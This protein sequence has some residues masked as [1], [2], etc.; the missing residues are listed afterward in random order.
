MRLPSA[1]LAATVLLCASAGAGLTAPVRHGVASVKGVKTDSYQWTDSHGRPR[2]VFLKR[3]GEGN[4]G[5]GGYAVRMTYQVL[6]SGVWRTV[7]ADAVAGGDGGFG[8]F[9]S[10]ERYRDFTDGA[11]DTIAGKIF[12]VD[13]SPLGLNFAVTGAS[14]ALSNP[15]AA[16]HR[17]KLSYPRYGTRAAIPKNADGEDVS[18]TPTDP[19]K[20]QRYL[21][22][23]T[24][25]WVFQDGTD[26]PR[27]NFRV[28]LAGLPGP[29]RA[30]FH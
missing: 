14:L 11:N 21:L 12:G 8:Y 9:V 24:I 27:I 5:H 19:A 18:K 16:A 2:A 29:E 26:F 6:Q 30:N 25:T 3:E 20:F 22:P 7:V 28:S 1:I 4:P 23:V 15:N 10:H 13:D 17:F